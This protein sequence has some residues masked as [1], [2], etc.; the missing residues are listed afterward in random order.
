M[1][2]V[3]QQRRE[4]R[5]DL[6]YRALTGATRRGLTHQVEQG[7]P[8]LPSGSQIILD[9]QTQQLV[10]ANIRSQ[11]NSRWQTLVSELRS[12]GDV[13]LAHFLNESGVELADVVRSDRSW[14]RLRRDTGL[15]T[16]GGDALEPALLKR[17]RSFGHV[18]DRDRAAVYR[19]VLADGAPGYDDLQPRR[20]DLR[21]DAALLAVAQRRVRLLRGR[22]GC[23]SRR[24]GGA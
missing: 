17:I 18:D 8:F 9:R 1:D 10:L 14:T 24:T 4:F 20:A 22:L 6:R 2:F 5:F 11:L 12:C 23:T 3:G 16:R 13:D 15:P 19:S 21:Q 7:F